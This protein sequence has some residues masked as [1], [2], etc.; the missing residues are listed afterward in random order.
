M[1]EDDTHG[2]TPVRSMSA[3]DQAPDGELRAL[4]ERA[5]AVLRAREDARMKEAIA[6]IKKLAKQHGLNVAI[7]PRRR[8][9]GRPPAMPKAGTGGDASGDGKSGKAQRGTNPL[10]LGTRR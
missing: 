8:R 10:A 6:R 2:T 9:R 5:A 1:T 4:I 7:E 3:L